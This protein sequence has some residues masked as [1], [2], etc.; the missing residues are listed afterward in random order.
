M[1][2][3][4]QSNLQSSLSR[5]IDVES[6][7]TTTTRRR[8]QKSND[9]TQNRLLLLSACCTKDDRY[10]ERGLLFSFVCLFVCLF[11]SSFSFFFVWCRLTYY[12]LI[13]LS[14]AA[15][16]VFFLDRFILLNKVPNSVKSSSSDTRIWA[17]AISSK[18]N[19]AAF[20]SPGRTTTALLVLLPLA[21]L[22]PWR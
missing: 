14:L 19:E 13:Y 4:D 11:V 16:R 5:E 6:G 7:D 8:R 22:S 3:K 9:V 2:T 18:L 1:E 21:G 20:C 17:L 10:R 12:V 15:H